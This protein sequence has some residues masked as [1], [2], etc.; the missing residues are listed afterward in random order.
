M[1]GS[2]TFLAMKLMRASRSEAR[3]MEAML[4]VMLIER[5]W[6]LSTKNK[7]SQQGMRDVKDTWIQPIGIVESARHHHAVSKA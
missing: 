6:T 3:K 7:R 4:L 2:E 1:R 5:V